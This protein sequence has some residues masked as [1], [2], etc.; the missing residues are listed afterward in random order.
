[1]AV[2]NCWFQSAQLTRCHWSKWLMSWKNLMTLIMLMWKNAVQTQHSLRHEWLQMWTIIYIVKFFNFLN[3]LHH[4]CPCRKHSVPSTMT[5]RLPGSTWRRS[6]REVCVRT[7]RSCRTSRRTW[8]NCGKQQKTW[9][10]DEN[11]LSKIYRWLSARLWYLQCIGAGV[12]AVS[13]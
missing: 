2:C 6:T 8:R 1:M 13:H 10:V 5:R 9:W 3:A 12:V 7:R 11:F 4:F